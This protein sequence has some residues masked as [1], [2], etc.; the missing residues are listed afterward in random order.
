MTTSKKRQH[1]DHSTWDR[2][3]QVMVR[4]TANIEAVVAAFLV[5]A[6]TTPKELLRSP[7]LPRRAAIP[8]G[9]AARRILRERR[10]ACDFRSIADDCD[11]DEDT[12][13]SE[14]VCP[15]GQDE[16]PGD[17]VE[18][19]NVILSK[20]RFLDVCRQHVAACTIQRAMRQYYLS[21]QQHSIATHLF[22][23]RLPLKCL[24]SLQ[25][26]INA[27]HNAATVLQ[28]AWRR[29]RRPQPRMR[30]L[31]R[32]RSHD[33]DHNLKPSDVCRQS[34]LLA[35]SL[36]RPETKELLLQALLC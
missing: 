3:R 1:H 27:K 10:Q 6:N 25:Q 17:W 8:S 13:G 34:A 28:M 15:V 19:W 33:C 31:K 7:Q 36:H 4:F 21:K 26:E 29:R 12:E 11:S 32:K 20:G 23:V 22:R 35:R 14:V 30:P 18:Q 2:F 5:S 24:F 16:M 9:R